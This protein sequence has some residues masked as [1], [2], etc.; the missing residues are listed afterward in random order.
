MVV[1]ECFDRI[2]VKIAAIEIDID[3]MWL[4][5]YQTNWF[6]CQQPHQLN[7]TNIHGMLHLTYTRVVV[8][9]LPSICSN[10]VFAYAF[11]ISRVPFGLTN[12][13]TQIVNLFQFKQFILQKFVLVRKFQCYA[14]KE[15]GAHFCDTN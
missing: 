1:L 5:K 2:S 10:C 11:Q 3:F 7:I 8:A 14:A 4:W 13:C 6:E 9:M 15:F 12:T